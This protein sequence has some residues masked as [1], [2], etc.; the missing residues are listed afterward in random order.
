ME[1]ESC[2]IVACIWVTLII[3]VS[4]ISLLFHLLAISMMLSLASSSL[5]CNF[6]VHSFIFSI[7]YY[8]AFLIFYINVVFVCEI[9]WCSHLDHV[10]ALAYFTEVCGY[11][12]PVYMT[13]GDSCFC[14][15]PVWWNV[16]LNI[17]ICCWLFFCLFIIFKWYVFN[18]ENAFCTKSSSNWILYSLLYGVAGV[19]QIGQMHVLLC[20]ISFWFQVYC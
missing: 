18:K 11:N 5:I 17:M 13:V 7:Y 20:D 3:V 4:L 1:N 19:T 14:I 6:I 16:C 9:K 12:G 8:I 15:L 10:G 2:S